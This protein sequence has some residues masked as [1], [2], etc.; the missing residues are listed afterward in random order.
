ML[1]TEAQKQAYLDYIGFKGTPEV[2]LKDLK[3]IVE[4]HCFTF[5]YETINVHDSYFDANPEHRSTIAFNPLFKKLITEKRG[6]RCVEL[7]MLLQTMLRAFDFDVMSILPEMLWH[8]AKTP[9]AKRPKH[10]AAII[11]ID[12]K[13]YLVDAAFGGI[14]IMSP[15]PLHKGEYQQ[16]SEKFKL[17][18]SNEYDFELQIQ[19][20]KKWVSIYGL[21]NKKT[22]LKSYAA[23]DHKNSNPAKQGALFKDLFIC[24]KPFKIANNQNGRYRICNGVFTLVE[25]GQC[26]KTQQLTSQKALQDV[27]TK[28]FGIDLK[29]HY[30]RHT[31]LEMKSHLIGISRPPILH[32]YNTRSWQKYTLLAK[33]LGVDL[34]DEIERK[35][36]ARCSK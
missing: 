27:L 12:D 1:P 5:A 14:G 15:L 28:Y 32:A 6:G 7:N 26:I 30:V 19:H 10:S 20:E 9:K 34:S 24:T 29:D 35:N 33:K 25:K 18:S 4:A 16:F 11:T 21:N 8:N 13:E 23:L 3:Q 31:P 17:A 36:R 2:T 22:T